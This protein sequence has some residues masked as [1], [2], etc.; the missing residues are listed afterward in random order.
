M[1][2]CTS[3]CW[4]QNDTVDFSPLKGPDSV[5]LNALFSLT[6]HM[7]ALIKAVSAEHPH[8]LSELCDMRRNA[9]GGPKKRE[10]EG[11]QGWSHR[12]ADITTHLV[13]RSLFSTLL[14]CKRCLKHPITK[15]HL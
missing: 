1:A 15:V 2:F 10:R 5:S 4:C 7:K 8:H 9:V 12:T 6:P 11:P 14:G 13:P 3:V